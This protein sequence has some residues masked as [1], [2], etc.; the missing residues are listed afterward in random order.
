[1]YV[2]V[3]PGETIDIGILSISPDPVWGCG[4]D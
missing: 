4:G 2:P 3:I 1:M